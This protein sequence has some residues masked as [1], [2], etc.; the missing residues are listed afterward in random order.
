MTQVEHY[1]P[2]VAPLLSGLVI[3]SG[4]ETRPAPRE[5]LAHNVRLLMDKAGFDQA[6]LAKRAGVSQ[7][8]ISN[9][10]NARTAPTLDNVERVA[11]AFGLTAWHLIMPNL[12]DELVAGGK[13]EKLVSKYIAADPAEREYIDFILDRKHN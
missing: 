11:R 13:I 8:T 5:S 7:K 10:V 6:D 9:L 12:P 2:T 3:V 4:M 1:S